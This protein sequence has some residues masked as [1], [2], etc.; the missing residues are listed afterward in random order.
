MRG[1]DR[2]TKKNEALIIDVRW[3][4]GVGRGDHRASNEFGSPLEAAFKH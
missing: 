3:R 4:I 1:W 2:A